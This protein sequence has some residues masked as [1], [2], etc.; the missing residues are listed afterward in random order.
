[1]TLSHAGLG[2]LSIVRRRLLVTRREGEQVV[3]LVR[4]DERIATCG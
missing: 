2:T 4:T 3:R 1:M